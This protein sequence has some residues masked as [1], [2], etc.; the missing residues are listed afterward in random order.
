M[1]MLNRRSVFQM[2]DASRSVDDVQRDGI[3]DRLAGP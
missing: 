1:W 3:D 2:E